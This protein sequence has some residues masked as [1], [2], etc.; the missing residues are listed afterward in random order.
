MF[1]LLSSTLRGY[2][3]TDKLQALNDNSQVTLN[4]SGTT[5]GNTKHHKRFGAKSN[6]SRELG[7][8]VR[9]QEE[10]ASCLS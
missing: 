9:Q 8:K 10:G 2:F 5:Q 6:Q 7:D 3:K 4:T 1:I